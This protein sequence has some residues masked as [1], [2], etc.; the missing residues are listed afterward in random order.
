MNK[1]SLFDGIN[2]K[3]LKKMFKCFDTRI[4]EYKKD[5]TVISNMAKNNLIGVIMEGEA[6]LVRYDYNGNRTILEHL[7]EGSVFGGIF[8][9]SNF[10]EISVHTTS[11][12]KIVMFDFDHIPKKCNKNCDYHTVLI[13]NMLSTLA[14]KLQKLNERI[15]ILTKKSTREKLLEYFENTGRRLGRKTFTLPMSYTDL[16]DY[17]GVDRSAL[18]RELKYLKD[19]GFIETNKKRITI[20]NY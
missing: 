5:T 9:S 13:N 4:I 2:E 12:S 7:E 19:D 1:S 6:V 16:A 15:E 14:E 18:M 20:I 17:F 10:N 8:L 11:Y 3:D